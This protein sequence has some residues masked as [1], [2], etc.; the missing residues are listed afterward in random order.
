[1]RILYAIQPSGSGLIE[2]YMALKSEKEDNF[3]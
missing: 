1:M 2:I 3:I